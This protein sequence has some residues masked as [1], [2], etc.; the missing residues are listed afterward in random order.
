VLERWAVDG[1][2][3]IEAQLAKLAVLTEECDKLFED[4]L[5]WGRKFKFTKEGD[6]GGIC[7]KAPQA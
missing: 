4:A 6:N 1:E 5:E 2:T 3:P 7:R